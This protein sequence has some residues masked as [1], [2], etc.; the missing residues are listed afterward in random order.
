MSP[1][2]HP[3]NCSS[4]SKETHTISLQAFC[5]LEIVPWWRIERACMWGNGATRLTAVILLVLP[6]HLGDDIG[7]RGTNHS[8]RLETRDNLALCGF[9]LIKW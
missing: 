6:D 9:E 1:F 7:Y 8:V 3:L 4:R 2:D 5:F